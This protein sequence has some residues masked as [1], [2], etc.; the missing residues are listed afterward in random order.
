MLPEFE[1]SKIEFVVLAWNSESY[2]RRCIESVL[3]LK[4][5]RLDLWVVD[6]GSID[7][8]RGILDEIAFQDTRLHV[9]RELRN[10]G[11]TLTRNNALRQVSYDAD[12]ICILDSDTMVNQGAFEK[13]AAV[14][15][16]NPD[17]GVIGPK[18]VNASGDV[19][20]SG[21][22]LPTLSIKIGKAWPFGDI[23]RRAGEAERPSTPVAVGDIQDVGYLLSA[24]WLMPHI[25]LEKVGLLDE[26]IFYAPEDVDWCLR[27]HKCGLRVILCHGACILHEYQRLS[28]RAL[29]SKVNFEHIKGLAYYFLKH[30]YLFK[31][32][33]FNE[34]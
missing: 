12:Y 23:S 26:K 30:R 24:C 11:T 34:V 5:A 22:N 31:A 33:S 4:C 2:I 32:P 9:I 21:R 14:L 6:N 28:H 3:S 15:R 17:I 16:S 29:V 10:L 20:L 13:M 27:C 18:M 1:D 25:S 8:T 7:G 19:Q